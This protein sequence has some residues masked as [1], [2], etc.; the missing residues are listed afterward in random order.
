MATITVKNVPDELYDRLKALAKEHR[1]S[2]NNEVIVLIEN[3]VGKK[4][5]STEEMLA[6][7][8]E[9]RKHTEGATVTDEEL[10]EWI[11]SGRP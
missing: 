11:N 5:M 4:R 8:R 10:D 6:M 3:H 9:V 7:A 1:R 2:I